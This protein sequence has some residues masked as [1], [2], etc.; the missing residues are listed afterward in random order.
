M[1]K[2][3][4]L[5]SCTLAPCI[6]KLENL[7]SLYMRGGNWHWDDEEEHGV[8]WETDQSRMEDV[9][10]R[11]SLEQ[12]AEDRILQNLRSRESPS[13]KKMQGLWL[14][15]YS[16]SRLLRSELSGLVS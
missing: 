11:T 5:S 7:R 8:K 13:K 4:D 2:K 16:D 6:E 12:P 9:L 15:I 14:T 10:E 3:V 1:A